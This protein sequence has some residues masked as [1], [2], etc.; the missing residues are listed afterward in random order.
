MDI[1]AD[2]QIALPPLN[3]FPG[4]DLIDG[5]RVAR[6]LKAFRNLPEASIEAL[7]EVLQRVSEIVCELPEL[8]ELDINPLLVDETGV[9][10]VDARIVVRPPKA[11][12]VP[13]GHMAIH[14][15][16]SELESRWQLPDGT[17]VLVR[18]I[19]PERVFTKLWL[20]GGLTSGDF[21]LTR[22][23]LRPRWAVGH[24]A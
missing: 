1:C 8:Q 14:P 20:S 4:R 21:Q 9:I 24:G 12:A 13:Y 10:A 7:I 2:N 18:P 17:D 22:P 19:R 23:T 5:S 6:V 11:S 3:D 15:Y 16:P